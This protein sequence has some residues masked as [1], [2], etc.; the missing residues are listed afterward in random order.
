MNL[1][2]ISHTEHYKRP[3][4]TIVGWGPTVTELNHLLEV[5]D[6]IY[7][8]AMLHDEEAPASALPYSSD[9]IVF[10][11]LPALGGQ[12]VGDKLKLVWKSPEVLRIIRQ[13]L[14]KVDWFQFRSPTGIG[15]Y[16]IPYLTFCAKT[17]GWFK[18][19][20][21][22]NQTNPPLGYR[23][24]RWM[25]KRQ[26]RKVTINGHWEN[27]PEHCLTFENPCLTTSELQQGEVLNKQKSFDGQL[28]FCYVGRLE[29][30]K[31]VERIIQAI[32]ELSDGEKE[33]IKVVHL[34]GDG[35]D[36]AA[37]MTLA[38]NSGVSFIFHGFLSRGQ[39][40]E[41][42]KES[43]V[44]LMPTTASEGFPKAIAEA[45][46]FG[47]MPV[48]SNISSIGQYIKHK[49][50]GLCLSEVTVAELTAMIRVLKSID[51]NLY[52][53]I[54]NN[55]RPIVDKFSFKHYN[56]RIIAEIIKLA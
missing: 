37:F 33:Q 12:S 26:S 20:G 40:F 2:V 1:A 8:V 29:K 36:K 34:V 44:F 25:L 46:N 32:T 5:F 16:V 4:G 22:W 45:M 27:Q 31:G 30:P 51:M 39:V 3:D 14:K 54:L 38:E 56:N 13:T 52:H 24:Q 55:Q 19:A 7:H 11:S 42:Y 47:C 41:I 21:N 6:T 43:Q 49:E 48:V 15:M 53:N 35:P 23:L 18:Y 9:K 10:I 50:T 28:T 17:P